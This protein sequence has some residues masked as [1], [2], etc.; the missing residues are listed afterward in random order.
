MRGVRAPLL[1][2]GFPVPGGGGIGLGLELPR[3]KVQRQVARERST[4]LTSGP[5]LGLL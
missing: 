5:R 1:G 2:P 4:P 3:D